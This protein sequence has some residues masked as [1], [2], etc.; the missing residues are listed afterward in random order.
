ML[1]AGVEAVEKPGPRPVGWEKATGSR[2]H[3]QVQAYDFDQ[4]T[5][6]AI[7]YLDQ[8]QPGTFE[9][10]VHYLVEHKL[11]LSVLYPRYRND[12]TGRCAYDPAI[13]R[14]FLARADT[15][16]RAVFKLWEI[17]DFQDCWVLH[18]CLLD[19]LFYLRFLTRT[20][21]FSNFEEWSFHEQ[22]KAVNRVR[23]DQAVEGAREHSLFNLTAEHR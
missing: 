6:V 22:Y 10:A 23:S 3:A 20:D 9:H 4:H 16:A 19:R 12:D 21:S 8:L 14:N 18:R 13:I 5:M 1:Y 15:T 11:D 2:R 17:H 7:N